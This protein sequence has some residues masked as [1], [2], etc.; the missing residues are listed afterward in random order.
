[1]IQVFQFSRTETKP[2]SYK[3]FK[4]YPTIT[5]GGTLDAV[6][7]GQKQLKM[8]LFELDLLYICT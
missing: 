1:M 2:T 6:C 8:K 5:D 3:L 4:I 7:Q